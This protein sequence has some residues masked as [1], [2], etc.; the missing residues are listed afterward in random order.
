MDEIISMTG[1]DGN[2]CLSLSSY[3]ELLDNQEQALKTDLAILDI[4]L[5]ENKPSG[6]DAEQWLRQN[7]YQGKVLFLTGHGKTN[8]LV[9]Q[10]VKQRLAE[11]I[12]KPLGLNHLFELISEKK[13]A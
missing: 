2:S 3:Q 10:A 8:P 11:V 12:E 7:S 6:L 4:N 13:S 9:I 1:E 5:G